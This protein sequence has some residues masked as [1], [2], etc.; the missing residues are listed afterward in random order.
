[1]ISVLHN[2]DFRYNT[3][4]GDMTGIIGSVWKMTERLTSIQWDAPRGVA[5]KYLDAVR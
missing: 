3:I 4:K 5:P 2:S 1:M